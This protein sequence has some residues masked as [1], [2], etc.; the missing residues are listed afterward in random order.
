MFISPMLP[1]KAEE[2]F[3]S[4]EYLFEPKLNG[5]RLMVSFINGQVNMYTRNNNEVTR[6]Y[7]ELF[8]VPVDSGMDVVFDGE[9]IR[10]REDGTNDFDELIQRFRIGKA[11]KIKE[12]SR[13]RPVHYYV[14]DILYLNGKSL[15]HLPLVKRKEILAKI[16]QPS[17]YYHA[18]MSIENRGRALF[19]VMEDK[20]L[21]GMVAKK[22][23]SKYVGKKSENWLKVLH[24]RYLE[25]SISAYRRKQFGWLVEHEGKTV[26]CIEETIPTEDRKVFYKLAQSLVTGQDKHFVYVKPVLK[27]RIRFRDWTANHMLRTPEYVEFTGEKIKSL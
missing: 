2:P 15:A 5:H 24:Y 11:T 27:V 1:M 7:P 4:E 17:I 8:N 16:L 22:K 26:G 19:K 12:A 10:L 3:D 20:G 13:T 14:F 18:T 23:N 21:E 9:V 6:Q 25:V